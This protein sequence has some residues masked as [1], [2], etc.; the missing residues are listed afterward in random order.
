MRYYGKIHSKLPIFRVN[1]VNIYTGQK[2]LH[3]NSRDSRDKYEVWLLRMHRRTMVNQGFSFLW[4]LRS[5]YPL[6]FVPWWVWWHY[7][8]HTLSSNQRIM[9]NHEFFI[10]FI[11]NTFC[12]GGPISLCILMTWGQVCFNLLSDLVKLYRYW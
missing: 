2:N 11:S 3:E 10:S 4:K 1:S 9:I 7:Y 12:K 8:K 5:V 6:D